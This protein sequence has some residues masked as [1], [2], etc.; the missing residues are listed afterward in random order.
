MGQKYGESEIL[1]ILIVYILF[2]ISLSGSIIIKVLWIPTVRVQ[3]LNSQSSLL[4]I[5]SRWES[6]G[7]YLHG[8]QH[9][10]FWLTGERNKAQ[11]D[12]SSLCI[13]ILA[14]RSTAIQ[15]LVDCETLFL[16]IYWTKCVCV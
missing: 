5:L 9:Q 2:A 4:S 6:G 16:C 14:R 10:K 11:D 15:S 3:D 8:D 12:N 13:F 7:I 1:N